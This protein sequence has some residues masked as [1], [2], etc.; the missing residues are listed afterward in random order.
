[1]PTIW[2]HMLKT[3]SKS[4]IKR[5]VKNLDYLERTVKKVKQNGN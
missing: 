3:W 2:E 4:L 5:N 1:M